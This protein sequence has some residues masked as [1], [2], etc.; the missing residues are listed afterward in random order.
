MNNEIIKCACGCGKDKLKYDS[1]GREHSYINHHYKPKRT[2]DEIECGCGCGEWMKLENNHKKSRRYLPGHFSRTT[3]KD[4]PIIVCACGC[5]ESFSLYDRHS[6][7]RKYITGHN[8]VKKYEDPTQYK[9]EWN[10]RNRESINASAKRWRMKK[11]L[12]LLSLGGNKCCDCNIENNILNRNIFHFHH[13]N[14]Q[15]L[16]EVFKGVNNRAWS[17]VLTEAAKCILLCANCHAIR[18]TKEIDISIWT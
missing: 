2:D 8:T 4:I 10:H 17:E 13:I 12:E 7:M 14:G 11:K 16:F 18:H 5:G 9:R 3:K 6:R 15:K 1:N